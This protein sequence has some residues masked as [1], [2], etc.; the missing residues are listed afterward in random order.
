MG[1]TK[2]EKNYSTCTEEEDLVLVTFEGFQSSS[3]SGVV[4]MSEMGESIGLKN[5]ETYS[6]QELLVCDS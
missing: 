6:V 1:R 4:K 5:P 2:E 3:E